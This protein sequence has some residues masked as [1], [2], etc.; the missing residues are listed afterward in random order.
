MQQ[1]VNA[2]L[3][4]LA[5]E[6]ND[7]AALLE[8]LPRDAWQQ[9]TRLPGWD[10]TTLVAHLARGVGRIA[11]YAATPLDEPPQR[12]RVSYLRY[13][14]A[15]MAADVTARAREAAEGATPASLLTALREAV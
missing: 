5:A 13:D 7:L 12:G 3:D 10:V 15:G 11:A 14:A 6:V 4:A 8:P 2:A 9:P 1:E